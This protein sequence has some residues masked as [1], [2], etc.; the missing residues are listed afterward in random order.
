MHNAAYC[1]M[2]TSNEAPIETSILQ[3]VYARKNLA[4]L[5]YIKHIKHRKTQWYAI[6]RFEVSA[7]HETTV[8]SYFRFI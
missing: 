3:S 5:Q 1:L 8:C 7:V 6:W 4:Y 2:G